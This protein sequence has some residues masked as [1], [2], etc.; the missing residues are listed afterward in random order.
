M[1]STIWLTNIGPSRTTPTGGEPRL[2]KLIFVF[3]RDT[4]A[5]CDSNR[6]IDAAPG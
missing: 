1:V 4:G 6:P 3:A 5:L 2:K